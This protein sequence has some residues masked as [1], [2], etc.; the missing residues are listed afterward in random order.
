L[1][2]PLRLADHARANRRGGAE[3][4]K[5][6]EPGELTAIITSAAA[7]P[8]RAPSASRVIAT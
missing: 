1:L 8:P 2:F 3:R 5:P 4:P 7:Q 6:G